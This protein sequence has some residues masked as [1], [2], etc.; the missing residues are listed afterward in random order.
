MNQKYSFD[1]PISVRP[2]GTWPFAFGPGWV[3]V[4]ATIFAAAMILSRYF[5][6]W[7]CF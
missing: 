1:S 5:F 4:V 7:P 3:L 6:G 2:A